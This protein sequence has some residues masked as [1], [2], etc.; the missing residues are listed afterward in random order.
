MDQEQ[1]AKTLKL[2]ETTFND[3]DYLEAE[4]IV[5]S[6]IDVNPNSVPVVVLL[7]F[8]IVTHRLGNAERAI[9]ILERIKNAESMRNNYDLAKALSLAYS[10]IGRFDQALEHR[11]RACSIRPDSL[12]D[13]SGTLSLLTKL[14]TSPTSSELSTIEILLGKAPYI[15]R[16]IYR[17]FAALLAR[18]NQV[19]RALTTY[20]PYF[21]SRIDMNQ[22]K[23]EWYLYDNVISSGTLEGQ[24]QR[25]GTSPQDV[26]AE[27]GYVNKS[28][29]FT[30]ND[31]VLDIGG[32][33]GLFAARMAPLVDQLTLTDVSSQL[34][35][36]AKSNLQPFTNVTFV[37]ADIC[38]QS[39]SGR[40]DKVLMAGVTPVFKDFEALKS[41]LAN[42]YACMSDGAVCLISNNYDII[43]AEP[44]MIF[45]LGNSSN[46]TLNGLITRLWIYENTFYIDIP[47]LNNS[48]LEIGYSSISIQNKRQLPD[49]REM[50]DILLVK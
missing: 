29:E 32:A 19:E 34:V 7:W 24:S 23:Q 45:A 17:Q 20:L 49:K 5:R 30:S 38:T 39:P 14:G 27:F 48:A 6:A 33:G 9:G 10:E 46:Y 50:F 31:M 43:S 22:T 26:E 8:G 18:Q 21:E 40:F 36:K 4:R 44:A 15:S 37:T 11:R 41:A 35:E 2:F 3:G 42:I 16:G 47:I 28:L 25:F 13:W 12:L 1:L